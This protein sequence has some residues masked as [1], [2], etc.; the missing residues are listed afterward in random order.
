LIV[1][2]ESVLIATAKAVRRF[3]VIELFDAS[4]TLSDLSALA[5][6]ILSNY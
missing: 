1:S 2:L 5:V 6:A 3:L 4:T